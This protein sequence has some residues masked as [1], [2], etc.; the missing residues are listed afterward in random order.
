[1]NREIFYK[2]FQPYLKM[3]WGVFE[4]K[5]DEIVTAVEI[6]YLASWY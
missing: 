6:K 2:Y 1:M 5:S 4:I 3:S